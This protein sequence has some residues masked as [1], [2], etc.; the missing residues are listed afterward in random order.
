MSNELEVPAEANALA[1]PVY[2]DWDSLIAEADVVSGY[3]LAK[4]EI[5]DD[6]A[7]VPFLVHRMQFRPGVSRPTGERDDKGKPV[8]KQGAYVTL[9]CRVAPVLNLTRINAARKASGLPPVLTLEALTVEPDSLIVLNDGSTGLYRQSVEYLAAKGAIILPQPIVAVGPMG[10]STY[11]LI[12]SEWEDVTTG[13]VRFTP[14]GF[15]E[16]DVPVALFAKRGLR[17]SDYSNELTAPGETAR[18]RYFA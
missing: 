12:P 18:T 17:L 7:G 2:G 8:L 15:Q 1:N 13:D 14:E 3:D 16:Y 10:M 4:D 5:A 11:D 9:S 6:L